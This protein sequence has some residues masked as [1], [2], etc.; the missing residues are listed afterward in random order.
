[1]KRVN[2]PFKM[3]RA[4]LIERVE[5]LQKQKTYLLKMNIRL[6]SDI[7]NLADKYNA[8]IGMLQHNCEVMAS[9]GAEDM[10]TIKE[11]M[12]LIKNLYNEKG[13]YEEKLRRIQNTNALLIGKLNS[14]KK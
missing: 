7:K 1:M 13:K 10:E 14:D 6:K 4:Q 5:N 11:N 9:K 2:N 8:D 12:E 3:N